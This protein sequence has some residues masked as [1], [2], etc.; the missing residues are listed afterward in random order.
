[1]FS[2]VQKMIQFCVQCQ[3]ELRG[4][5]DKRFCSDS[6]RTQYHNEANRTKNQRFNNVHR[7]LGT[8]TAPRK[9]R[10]KRKSKVHLQSCGYWVTTQKRL[11]GLSLQRRE[12]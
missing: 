10:K 8:G 7:Q 3:Q 5:I 11:L 4:R 2:F 1:M 12:K 6:C 9:V